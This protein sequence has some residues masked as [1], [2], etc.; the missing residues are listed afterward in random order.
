MN[1]VMVQK[2]FLVEREV[3][4]VDHCCAICGVDL[5]Q[6]CCIHDVDVVLE[7][8]RSLVSVAG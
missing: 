2:T 1:A 8:V 3:D 4:G 6:N 7:A 5:Q